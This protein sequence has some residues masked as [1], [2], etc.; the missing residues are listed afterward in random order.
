MSKK[1][2]KIAGLWLPAIL[3]MAFIFLL[4]SIPDL[5]SGLEK[6][7]DLILRKI[8]H[9][10]EYAVL[11]LLLTRPLDKKPKWALVI[12]VIYASL[13]EFHQNFV[14]GRSMALA[15]VCF[16]AAGVLLGYWWKMKKKT[17]VAKS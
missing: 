1:I 13:D 6:V 14:P 5:Q 8:A 10:L 7:Y 4:S 3:W 17:C 16:D 11:F 15:D 12:G 9:L 2:L